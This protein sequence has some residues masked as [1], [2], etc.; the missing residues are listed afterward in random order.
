MLIKNQLHTIDQ[1]EITDLFCFLFCRLFHH[2]F[3]YKRIHKIHHEWTAPIGV[4]SLYA[5]P[6]EHVVCV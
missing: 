4:V 3:F 1:Q 2:P 6:V 5:H